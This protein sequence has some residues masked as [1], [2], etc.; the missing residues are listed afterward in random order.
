MDKDRIDSWGD[1]RELSVSVVICAYT[2]ARWDQLLASIESV[3]DQDSKASELIVVVDHSEDLLL[4]A[5]ARFEGITVIPNAEAPGLSGARNTGVR[6]STGEIVA[7]LDDD[8]RAS[9]QWLTYLVEPYRDPA[10]QGVG[11]QVIPSWSGARPGWFPREFD[12][13]VGCSY[14]GLPE[15]AGPVRNFIGANMSF[16]RGGFEEVGY[17]AS[18]V[19][20]NA[21]APLGC[22]E[23]EFSIR[24]RQ[25]IRGAVLWY[26]PK[27]T[28]YHHV[29]VERMTPSYFLRRCFAE[30]LSKAVVADL[31]GASEATSSE[32]SYVTRTLSSGAYRYLRDSA[33]GLEG[34]R[35]VGALATGLL[36]TMLAYG[37]GRLGLGAQGLAALNHRSRRQ[38]AL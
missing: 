20:R 8:A 13:V 33:G 15:H 3:L 28:V 26:E 7:F 2:L 25:R 32:R 5:R 36:A 34:V 38:V 19:G 16:R 30:G 31:V 6:S 22:E 27:A 17:F 11:G 12:W 23:T 4:R 10:V 21:L 1:L 29:P 24:L 37:S 14:R 35:P 9:A 18:S